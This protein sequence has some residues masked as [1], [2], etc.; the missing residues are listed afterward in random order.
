MDPKTTPVE[1]SYWELTALRTGLSRVV[2]EGDA[3]LGAKLDA[4]AAK[5]LA[6]IYKVA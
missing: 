2:V 4:L 6:A 3:A 1:L 5:L